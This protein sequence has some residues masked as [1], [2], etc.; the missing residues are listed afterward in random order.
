VRTLYKNEK[1]PQT[2]EVSSTCWLYFP[3]VVV[4]IVVVEGHARIWGIGNREIVPFSC[5]LHYEEITRKPLGLSGWRGQHIKL[6]GASDL[7]TKL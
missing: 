1:K 4:E 3:Q 2:H 5:K 7:E 6:L